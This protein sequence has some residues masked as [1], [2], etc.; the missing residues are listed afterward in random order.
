MSRY[1]TN[2]TPDSLSGIIFALEGISNS[3]TILNGPT[4]CKFYHSATSDSQLIRQLEFDPLNFPPVW[5]FGQPRVPCTYLDTDDYVYGSEDKLVEILTYVRESVR[6]DLVSIVN[7]PGAALIGDDLEGIARRVLGEDIPFVT[8]E[9]PGFSSDV[10]HGH[11]IAVKEV[12]EQLSGLIDGGVEREPMS[13]NVLGLSLIQRYHMGDLME[14]ER[15]L[16][17]CGIKVNCFVCAGS[18]LEQIEQIPRAS[19][20]IVIHPEFGCGSAEVLE[21]RYGIPSYICDGA[22]IGFDATERF[23]NDVCSSLGADPGAAIDDIL[24]ARAR[25]YAFI[26]RVHSLT[27]MPK[28]V[29]YA[30]EGRCSELCSYIEFLTGYMGMVPTAVSILDEGSSGY[31]GNLENLLAGYGFSDALER[32]DVVDA[33]ADLLFASGSTIATAKS[34]GRSFGGIEISLPTL[35]YYDVVPKTVL[36]PNGALMLVEMV[37]NGL[38]Y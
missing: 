22:P 11:E 27:G 9:T 5:Y 13:V 19:L 2:I 1:S 21:S 15:L 16:G 30:I 33:P 36:G 20:D 6:F 37:L 7:S 29:P 25:S 26:S 18:A 38:M 35:G 8:I 23:I 14:I 4:G 24:R 32:D 10:C 12:M 28:G 31:R 34:T 17:L 3:L